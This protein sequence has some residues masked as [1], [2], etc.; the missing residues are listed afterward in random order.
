MCCL[1]ML[2]PRKNEMQRD[3]ATKQKALG[4]FKALPTKLGECPSLVM[5][6]SLLIP[7]SPARRKDDASSGVACDDEGTAG[8]YPRQTRCRHDRERESGVGLR[9]K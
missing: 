3:K 2:M 1:Q 5:I 7:S 9:C 6:A 8:C 4:E